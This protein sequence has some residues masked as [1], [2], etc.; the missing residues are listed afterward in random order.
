LTFEQFATARLHDL[1]RA[2]TAIC[3]DPVLAE[4]LV[5]EVLI[6][7]QRHWAQISE[8]DVPEAYVRKMLVNEFLSSRRK[9][10][11]VRP[12]AELESGDTQHERRPHRRRKAKDMIVIEDDL[13]RYYT[14]IPID[15]A[16]EERL[17]E[18]IS[19][20]A[21]TAA[22]APSGRTTEP[23]QA[24]PWGAAL[25]GRR[26]VAV[27]AAVVATCLVA[28]G[29]GL[30]QQTTNSTRPESAAEPAAPSNLLSPTSGG[31]SV[32]PDAATRCNAAGLRSAGGDELVGAYSLSRPQALDY[33]HRI[34]GNHTSPELGG[35]GAPITL[36]IVHVPGGIPVPHPPPPSGATIA[37]PDYT[38]TLLDETG[39]AIF[40]EGGGEPPVP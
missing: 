9:A 16:A 8:L 35:A 28:I 5:Q 20:L 29:I 22:A 21:V 13:S 39:S 2:A 12:V 23:R 4:D 6:K 27:A 19:R 36:C 34:L 18:L 7:T 24:K 37:L 3:G 38:V 26:A 33:L 32:D 40:S 10:A 1:L 30:A 31:F 15:A 11:R 14:E 25:R 17:H